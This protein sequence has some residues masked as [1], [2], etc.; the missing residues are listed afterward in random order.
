MA[1][2]EGGIW[3][4]ASRL[5]SKKMKS[6]GVCSKGRGGEWLCEF[7]YGCPGLKGISRT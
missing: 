3:S 4:S 5:G 1:D 6:L 2:D 7:F